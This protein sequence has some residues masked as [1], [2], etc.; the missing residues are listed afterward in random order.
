MIAAPLAAAIDGQIINGIGRA[1]RRQRAVASLKQCA[2]IL[3]S[4]PR[5]ADAVLLAKM[6]SSS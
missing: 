4:K 1:A 5:H 2:V 6:T 3:Q